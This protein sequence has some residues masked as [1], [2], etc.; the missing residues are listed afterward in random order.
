MLAKVLVV[1]VII[2]FALAKEC[3]NNCS[4]MGSCNQQT[5]QCTCVAQRVGL[6]CS[7]PLQNVTLGATLINQYV[8]ASTWLFYAINKP[9]SALSQPITV[10]VTETNSDGDADMYVRRNQ[11]PTLSE[12]DWRDITIKKNFSV[13]IPAEANTNLY[14]VG[15]FGFKN[16][17]FKINFH[18]DAASNGCPDNCN[19]H[20]N[21][22]AGRCVCTAPWEGA[23]CTVSVNTVT[24][25]H[26]ETDVA[27]PKYGWI[28]F[29]VRPTTNELIWNVTETAES[30]VDIYV[31]KGGI[32]SRVN[33]DYAE[34]G[35]HHDFSLKIVDVANQW[36]YFGFYAFRDSHFSWLLNSAVQQKCEAKCS[37]H[38]RC[39]FGNTCACDASYRG[40]NCE[41]M[42]RDLFAGEKVR[43]YVDNYE[44]NFY[45]FYTE[46]VDSVVVQLDHASGDCDLYVRNET[47]PTRFDYSYRDLSLNNSVTLIVPDPGHKHWKIGVYGFRECTYN[48]TVTVDSSCPQRCVHGRCVH[49]SGMC[50]CEPGWAGESC[51]IAVAELVSNQVVNVQIN[52]GQWKYFKLPMHRAATAFNVVLKESETTGAVWLFADYGFYPDLRIYTFH[53]IRTNTAIHRLKDSSSYLAYW[54]DLYVGVYGSPFLLNPTTVQLYNFVPNF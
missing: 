8:E 40:Q 9:Q 50:S 28:Y 46:S 43:G 53:D 33:F 52:P 27:I 41:Q 13:V 20:G 32:P 12:Y 37:M 49:E 45:S 26:T 24:P 14:Y 35:I 15:I 44:W 1:L 5:G 18:S 39:V 6:D 47:N 31:K 25:P 42:T 38:G 11:L 2:G 48:L 21:C 3:P 17:N 29:K 36:V 7:I 19:G 51:D 16:T 4:N 30:D 22:V 10:I 34:T 23:N 54:G